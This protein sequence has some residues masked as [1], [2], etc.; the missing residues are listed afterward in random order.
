MQL[1]LTQLLT[2][3][4]FC[5][6]KRQFLYREKKRMK[7]FIVTDSSMRIILA[8]NQIIPNPIKR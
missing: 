3:S 4:S 8:C 7:V 6:E 5:T 1:N 2:K